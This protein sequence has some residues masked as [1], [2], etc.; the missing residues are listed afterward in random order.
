VIGLARPVGGALSTQFADSSI[1]VLPVLEV[2]AIALMP[3]FFGAL[4]RDRLRAHSMKAHHLLSRVD[5][6]FELHNRPSRMFFAMKSDEALLP[7]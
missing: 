3:F 4:L 6:L 2:G 1:D 5:N 7:I